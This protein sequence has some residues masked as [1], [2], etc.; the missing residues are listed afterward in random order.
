M[1]AGVLTVLG[2]IGYKLIEG[3]S[4]GESFYMVFITLSTVGFSEVEPLSAVGRIWTVMLIVAGVGTIGYLVAGVFELLME[5]SIYGF[6]RQKRME[7]LIAQLL[8]HTIICGYGRVGRQVVKDFQAAGK[9]IVVVD[10]IDPEGRLEAQGIPHVVGKAESES[11][12]QAAGIERAAGIVAAVDSD[13]ENV[14]ITLTARQLN[15]EIRVIARASDSDTARKL[16]LVGAERVVSPYVASG[17]RMAHLALRPHAV[18]FFDVLSDPLRELQVEMHEIEITAGSQL[19][20]RTLRDLDLRGTTGTIAV[21]L[22]TGTHTALNPDPDVRME[23]G[24]RLVAMGTA[25]QCARLEELNQPQAA[26][27]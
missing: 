7:N 9:E 27:G 18:D 16:K 14:F 13:T 5:G 3:W 21:A 17:K 24:S 11:T 6:R 26:E 2:G 19:A 4:W 12:L 10:A 22:R 25:E 8:G 15:P 1:L 23:V 20:G